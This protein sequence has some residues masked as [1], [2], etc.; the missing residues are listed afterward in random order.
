MNNTIK[1]YKE[2]IKRGADNADVAVENGRD[3]L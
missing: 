2:A 3:I 1:E